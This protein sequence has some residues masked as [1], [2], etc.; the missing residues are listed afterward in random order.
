MTATAFALFDTAVGRCAITWGPHGIL[1]VQLPEG[2]EPETRAR[3]LRLHPAALESPPPAAV[4]QAVQAISAVLRGE[5]EDLSAL[6]L[7]MAALPDFHRRVYDVARTIGPGQ[8]LSY[9]EIADRLGS[10]GLSRAVG[11]ALGRNPFLIVVPCHRVLAAGGRVGGFS[12]SG[13]IT[14]KLRLLAIEGRAVA[15][16]SLFDGDGAYAFDAAQ[17]VAQL[18]AAD[19]V[20]ARL[21][22][23]VG[24]FAMELKTT[25][26][27]FVALAESIVYQ[28]L[29]GKAAATIFARVQALF[30]RAHHGPTPEQ[31]LRVSDERLRGAGLSNA[32]LLALRDLARRSVDGTVPTLAAAQQMDDETLVARLT[33]VRGIGRWTVEML[34][35]FRLGRPDVLPVDDYGVRQGFAIAFRK[36]K[37]PLPKALAKYGQRWAPYRT[38]ASWY[39]WRAVDLS[40]RGA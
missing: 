16:P 13:G 8:T 37:P 38:V 31:I 26:S 11:Q 21:I 35:M 25:P 27:L 33:E 9:G 28:Q 6:P 5:H 29:T 40:K 1:A 18:R 22:D 20:M 39:L 36:R 34:L 7:D 2:R 24:P 15:A 19:P 3:V 17:A 10:R 14:T 30:P 12:A 23:A 4:A 32:K